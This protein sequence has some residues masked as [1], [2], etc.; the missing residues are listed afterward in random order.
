[1]KDKKYVCANEDCRETIKLSDEGYKW[2]SEREIYCGECTKEYRERKKQE[3]GLM[4]WD[5]L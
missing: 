4:H 1:M 2:V 5:L 3:Q